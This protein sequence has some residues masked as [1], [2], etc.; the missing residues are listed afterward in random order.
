M[1]TIVT[2]NQVSIENE[3]ENRCL[4]F[5]SRSLNIDSVDDFSLHPLRAAVPM[6]LLITFRYRQSNAGVQQLIFPLNN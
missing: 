1:Y 6:S 3:A 2:E 5:K 4:S